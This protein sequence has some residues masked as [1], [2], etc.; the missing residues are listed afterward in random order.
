M[1]DK[2]VKSV[3]LCYTRSCRWNSTT[4]PPAGRASP[5]SVRNGWITSLHSSYNQ[6]NNLR[7]KYFPGTG[8]RFPKL[9]SF[10]ICTDPLIVFVSFTFTDTENV[11]CNK[12]NYSIMTKSWNWAA[13]FLQ[14]RF[15]SQPSCPVGPHQVIHICSGLCEGT[16]PHPHSS[17]SLSNHLVE[18]VAV[19]VANTTSTQWKSVPCICFHSTLASCSQSFC[20]LLHA[21]ILLHGKYLTVCGVEGF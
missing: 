21:F 16:P 3:V 1:Q 17:V 13:T 18:P 10:S 19:T 2:Y 5:D 6:E 11:L 4:D 7:G 8:G 12:Q 15:L 20:S 14:V 9:H